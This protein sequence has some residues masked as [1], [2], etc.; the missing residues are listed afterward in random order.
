VAQFFTGYGLVFLLTFLVTVCA[1]GLAW[2]AMEQSRWRGRRA[3]G[4]GSETPSILRNE[5]LSTL[6]LFALVLE[7]LSFVPKLK[8][9]LSE[10]DLDWSVGRTV[11]I[12]LVAGAATLNVLLQFDFVP[13]WV[14]WIAGAAATGG[15]I[16]YVRRLRNKRL[17]RVEEQLP[18][19]LDY[20]ARALVAGH[21]L[22]MSLE[23]LA[24]EVSPPLSTELRKT[25][26]EYNL[27]MSMPD[28]LRNL[29]VRLP[30]VDIQF[31]VSAILTQSRTGGNLHELLEALAETIRE[32]ATLRGQVRA[33]TANGRMTAMVLSLLPF[34]VA[35]VML[36]VNPQ[37]FTLLLVH[38]IGKTLLFAALVGQGLAYVVIRKIVDIRV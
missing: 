18:E 23:L 26:D 37:Y 17:Y 32:R 15:A 35:S 4:G 33:L 20:L 34:V 3:Q 30:S 13:V 11:L 29:T 36:A 38:P 8:K 10:A 1:A 16:F 21:S 25:V 7:R 27:G 5:M 31:F 2:A 19:A 28:S 14:C 24:D 12:M 22:P 9:L 6:S